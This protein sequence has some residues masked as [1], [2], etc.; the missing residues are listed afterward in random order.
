[1]KKLLLLLLIP[2]ALFGCTTPENK[3]IATVAGQK[4][5][6]G[7][8]DFEA[9]RLKK[10]MV[11]EDYEMT[12]EE[13]VMFESQILNNM[14]MK[15]VYTKKL[16]ELDIQ[17]EESRI[18]DHFSQLIKQYGTEEKMIE[19]VTAK[20]FTVDE[21]KEELAY[22]FRLQELAKHAAEADIE[23][24]DDDLKAY[25]DEKKES[26]FAQPGKVNSARHI[27]IKN[28]DGNPNKA[29]E[30]IKEIKTKIDE[31]ME[32]AEAAKEFSEGPSGVN[33]GQLGPFQQGQMVKEF[34]M[35]A[36]A[37]PLN[38][39]SE[40]VLTQFGYHLILVEDRT[41]TSYAPFEE[42]KEYITTQLKTERFF[43]D[44]E[45]EAKIKRPEWAEP[46]A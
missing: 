6:Q 12:E 35:V 13:S 14:I 34:E 5:T 3:A 10:A 44:I 30:K 22:Q 2:A 25:Y 27:L 11:P 19:D 32:F 7:E 28:E 16:D 40:P 4:I 9:A 42:T 26:V 45:A 21:L 38:Q 41:D 39:V 23:L 29:L 18:E 1:M 31:G 15:K 43:S 8:F 37:I 20:G 17:V 33:G 36:F 24:T 46:K